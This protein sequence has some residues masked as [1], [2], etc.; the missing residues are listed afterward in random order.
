VFERPFTLVRPVA[1]NGSAAGMIAF[2]MFLVLLFGGRWLLG[3]GVS[4]G[5]AT[6]SQ[7]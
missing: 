1:N 7:T 5:G 3:S 2:L 4:N 6:G